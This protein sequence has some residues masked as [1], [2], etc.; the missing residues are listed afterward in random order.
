CYTK[1]LKFDPK[2]AEAHGALGQALLAQ[3]DFQRARDATQ[4]ALEL[5]PPGHPRR[6]LATQQLE[7]CQC[8]LDL[9]TRLPAILKGE[10]RARGAA[11]QLVL[12]Y[13]CQHFKK[14]YVAAA[15]FY[16]D[17][18]AAKPKLTP[19]EQASHQYNAACAAAL[20][21]AGEGVDADKI[22]VKEK[23]QLRQ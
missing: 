3:G 23:T 17:A 13:L 2:L 6:L 22:A 4:K 12:A 8:R 16:V 10:D 18:L 20:A 21:A 15:R 7:T 14:R 1:A 11:E 19:Q 5:L 9:D